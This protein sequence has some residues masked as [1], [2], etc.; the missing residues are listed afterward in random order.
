MV[1]GYAGWGEGR[2]GGGAAAVAEVG[3]RQGRCDVGW[4]LRGEDVMHLFFRS[5]FG[6]FLRTYFLRDF[7][8]G[9]VHGGNGSEGSWEGG[10]R[11]V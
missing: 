3:V 2:T 5:F 9:L 10:G 4:G 8:T 6:S 11:L 7:G 1:E